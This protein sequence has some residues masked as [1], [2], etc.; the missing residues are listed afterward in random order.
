MCAIAQG[1][2]GNI[3]EDFD[4]RILGDKGANEVRK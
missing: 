4:V 2:D 1:L 3:T